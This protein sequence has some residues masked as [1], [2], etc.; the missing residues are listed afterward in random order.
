MLY[1][2]SKFTAIITEY[3]E[4]DFITSTLTTKAKAVQIIPRLTSK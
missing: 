3:G 4:S 1:I 2:G